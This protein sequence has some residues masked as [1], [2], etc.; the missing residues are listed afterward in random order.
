MNWYKLAQYALKDIFDVG[1]KM[2]DSV[3]NVKPGYREWLWIY[4][5]AGLRLYEVDPTQDRRI[6]HERVFGLGRS[7]DKIFRGRAEKDGDQPARVSIVTPYKGLSS[8][9]KPSN[10][11]YRTLEREFGADAQFYI[12]E[13]D[14]LKT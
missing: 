1:H 5:E 8:Y 11:L 2:Y 7:L 4:D 10:S 9:L 12:S 3:R 6:T 13:Y 14:R